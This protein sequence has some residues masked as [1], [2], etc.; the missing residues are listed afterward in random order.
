MA[1]IDTR[2]ARQTLVNEYGQESGGAQKTNIEATKTDPIAATSAH[3]NKTTAKETHK[4][5][6]AKTK[7]EQR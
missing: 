1:H 6:T 7:D 2:K 5:K 4:H 3:T